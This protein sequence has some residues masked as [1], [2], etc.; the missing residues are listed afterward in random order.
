MTSS[1]DSQQSEAGFFTTIRRWGITRGD[2]GFLGG[3]VDGLAQRVGMATGPARIIVVVAALFLNG[4]VL[5]AY[6]AGWALLPDRR[7]NIIVQN[8]ARGVPNVGALIGIGLLGILGLGG[9]DNGI[10]YQIGNFPF[11][12]GPFRV[13]AIIFAVL[14]PLAILAGV[15]GLIVVL[16]RRGGQA[17]NTASGPPVYAAM[18]GQAPHQ[19]P[20]GAAAASP[21]APEQAVDAGARDAGAGDAEAGDAGAAA[22]AATAGAAASGTDTEA[23]ASGEAPT[24]AAASAMPS[25][26]TYAPV[27]PVPPLKPRVPGPG[28]GFYLAT[29]AWIFLSAA[30]VALAARNDDLAVHGSVAWFVTFVA[31]LGVL[32]ILISLS[33]RKLGFLGFV[34][35]MSVL[36]MIGIIASAEDIRESYARD[37]SIITIDFGLEP[38]E[39]VVEEFDAT[40]VFA[41]E[42]PLVVINGGCYEETLVPTFP[43]ST[44]RISAL[45]MTEDMSVDVTAEVT[46]VSVPAGTS[47]T[48]RGEGDAQ[49]HVV[50]PERNITCDFYNAGGEHLRIAGPTHTLELVVYDDEYANTI[51]LTEV[52]Q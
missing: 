35:I 36:P 20:G 19:Q 1:P 3:V 52:S 22:T 33:G 7:G 31:G 24:A 9:I 16:S 10:T 2:N 50:W 46:H 43:M 17:P 8:F 41:E 32:L 49:A 21:A 30:G 48:V 26:Q 28:R 47:I 5:L 38:E 34:G 18:P 6:A 39:S 37:E 4:I 42:F 44:A 11:D 29:L 14:V 51:V 40:A 12:G 23:E 27:P 13:V 15:I 45:D 25:A